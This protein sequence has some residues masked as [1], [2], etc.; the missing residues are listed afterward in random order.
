MTQQ[1]DAPG[2][3]AS[4]RRLL[5]PHTPDCQFIRS[6]AYACDCG[7]WEARK[8]WQEAASGA[9]SNEPVVLCQ[10]CGGRGPLLLTQDNRLLCASCSGSGSFQTYAPA[11]PSTDALRDALEALAARVARL[12]EIEAAR[13]DEPLA[14]NV[15]RAYERMA[16][17][18]E[19]LDVADAGQRLF[20][21]ACFKCG[22][23]HTGPCLTKD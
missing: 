4:M 23:W 7:A 3:T 13:A 21:F 18:G 15:A 16:K 14:P 11:P 17:L 9:L 12:E 10:H 19:P 2:Y 1:P 5:T 20:G 8:G 6:A 22:H